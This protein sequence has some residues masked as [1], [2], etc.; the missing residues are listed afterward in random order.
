MLQSLTIE[1]Y[2][3]IDK[4]HITFPD[5]LSIITGETGAGKSILL[6]ALSLILGQRADTSALK[7]DAKNCV[8]EGGFSIDGYGL[9][10][11]FEENDIDYA[12]AVTLRRMIV[13]GG[14]SRAFVNDVPVTLNVLKELGERLIDIHSQHQNLLLNSSAFQMTVIDAQAGNGERLLQYRQIFSAYKAA[15]ARLQALQEKAARSK[16]DYDYLHFQYSELQAAHLQP[17]EQQDL[18]DELKQL[19]HAE[20]IKWAL[21]KSSA[22]LQDDDASVD[23]L[24]R[25]AGQELQRIAAVW[26][27]AAPLSER[28]ASC[29][30]ELR[31]VANEIAADNEKIAT[32]ANRLS[33]VESRLN[34]IYALQ[35]K[36]RLD[37]AEAL[38][39]LQEQLGK[40]IYT[41]ENYDR[42]LAELQETCAQQLAQLK[43]SAA[44]LSQRRKEI[45]PSVMQY[46]TD[47]LHLLGMPHAV[48]TVSVTGTDA[49]TAAGCDT[50][51]FLFS[52]NKEIPPQ[53]I[54]RV[55]SGGEISRL[56][57]CLKSLLVKTS[58]LPTIIF[59]EIDTGVSGEVAD[60]MGAII[61]GLSE[62]MQVINITHLPQIASK[63]HAHFAVYKEPG[64]AGAAVTRMKLLT[65]EE[66][67]T[68]IAKMLSG[69]NITQA[70]INNAKELLRT[71]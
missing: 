51:R 50:V 38:L 4:L 10:A 36:H 19:T 18:E 71:G 67:I 13:P 68:E 26:P 65:P 63:G 45:T 21:T 6:G 16:A 29:R 22:L 47:M 60:K 48:F 3:L 33:F 8:V 31:D 20:E 5:G 49:C 62:H 57:L 46:I 41:I 32:D 27:A 42:Q 59:D 40:N 69:Q 66:R 23:N 64:A 7:N 55:A 37:S 56:M 28:I 53:E 25:D 24:L 35:Q 11:V 15:C 14:K 34:T 9:A 30:V 52:A 70:A 12:P 54:A 2:A 17:G 43:E 61:Y 1:N 58:G 39:A 44:Q